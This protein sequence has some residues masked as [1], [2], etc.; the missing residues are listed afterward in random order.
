MQEY[1]NIVIFVFK[2]YNYSFQKQTFI[3]IIIKKTLKYIPIKHYN[4]RLTVYKLFHYK[5]YTI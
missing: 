1:I 2:F 4:I 5:Y 3:I